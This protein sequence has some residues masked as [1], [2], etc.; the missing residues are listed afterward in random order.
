MWMGRLYISRKHNSYL[1][2]QK[3]LKRTMNYLRQT[4]IRFGIVSLVVTDEHMTAKSWYDGSVDCH[5]NCV[6]F[7]GDTGSIYRYEPHGI[8]EAHYNPI[9]VQR[10]LGAWVDSLTGGVGWHVMSQ[11]WIPKGRNHQLKEDWHNVPSEI[12]DAYTGKVHKTGLCE[13]WSL[14]FA[15]I[16]V[17]NPDVHPTDIYIIIDQWPDHILAV[18]I[19]QF[20]VAIQCLY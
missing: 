14:F 16:V 5:A 4:E 19:R 17:L 20:L 6:I 15:L 10:L 7:D 3:S 8:S 2:S 1:M 18:R 13:V 9:E 11:R 12:R